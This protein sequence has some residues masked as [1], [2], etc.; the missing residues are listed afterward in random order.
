MTRFLY[1]CEE[2]GI[3]ESKLKVKLAKQIV[4]LADDPQDCS[5]AVLALARQGV[6]AESTAAQLAAK[7]VTLQSKPKPQ[8]AANVFLAFFER[9]WQLE[10]KRAYELLHLFVSDVLSATPYNCI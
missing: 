5:N 1:L 8:A 10:E 9:G 7:M 3:M 4:M 2:F 6:D